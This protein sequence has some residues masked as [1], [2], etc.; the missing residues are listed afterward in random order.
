MHGVYVVI[1]FVLIYTEIVAK[2]VACI[3]RIVPG[4]YL[5]LHTISTAYSLIR[6]LAFLVPACAVLVVIWTFPNAVVLQTSIYI[7]LLF[8]IYCYSIKLSYRWRVALGPVHSTIVAYIYTAII[9]IYKMLHI[10]W[11]Y[12]EVMIVHVYI[13]PSRKG[14]SFATICRL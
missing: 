10:I 2:L 3:D 6:V 4:V 12:P 7:V 11:I 13:V 1:L 9:S 5:Y 14:E 8:M